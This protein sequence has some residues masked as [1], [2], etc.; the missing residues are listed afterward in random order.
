[1]SNLIHQKYRSDIQGLRALAVISVILFHAFPNIFTG[2]F[3]GVDIFF[4]ISGYL[5]S[6]IIFT[7]LNNKNFNIF[8]FYN[9]RIKRIF[10]S[11]IIVIFSSL[12]F[13]WFFLFTYEYINLGKYTAS[14][15]IFLSDIFSYKQSGYFDNTS[16]TKPMLHLWSLSVEWQFYILWPLLLIFSWKHKWS[17]FQVS[18]LI[19]ATSFL[20]NIILIKY[21]PVAS[22]YLTIARVWELIIGGILAYL[23][24]EYKIFKK[25]NNIQSTAGL[26][27]II[28]GF[29][30]INKESQFPGWLALLPTV[31]TFLILSAKPSSHLNKY[32]FSNK[33]LV[34][35]GMISYPLYLWHWPMLSFLHIVSGDNSKGEQKIIVILVSILFAW[36]T[37]YFVEKK[38][39]EKKF[40]IPTKILL[41]ITLL[42]FIF[43]L[44]IKVNGGFFNRNINKKLDF[45]QTEK[46]FSK[47]RKSDK[48]CASLN[49]LKL[50]DEEV[51]LSNSMEPKILFI[52]D[53]HSMALYSSIYSKKILIN[54]ILISGHTCLIYP[55]LKYE[56]SGSYKNCR[57]I[58]NK[59]LDV[60][61]NIPS[62]ETIIVATRFPFSNQDS[63]LNSKYYLDNKILKNE[64]A[65]FIGTSNLI[66]QLL[67]YGKRII[68]VIDT[69]ELNNTPINCTQ[70]TSFFA[71]LKKCEIT[72]NELNQVRS[73]YV[74]IIKKINLKYP[75][76]KIFDPTDFFC[77]HEI[78]KAKE[79]EQHLYIDQN[80]ISIYAS[81]KLLEKM[82]LI[83]LINY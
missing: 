71:Q 27:L 58:S 26:F 38:L 32:L 12:V 5:I 13:G 15:I 81:S 74:D 34:Y 83:G 8:Y 42:I 40:F 14:S 2:G 23:K 51:C 19:L 44:L 73:K 6:T 21:N 64:D 76:I 69:P 53:S 68:I 16:D 49:N 66:E 72:I 60:A 46:L 37:Y 25:N 18:L 77:K 24:I 56:K 1:M 65:F 75:Q 11:L 57:E 48:S 54:S 78:C 43:S 55:N 41:I 9:R 4:V 59:A 33:I 82:K 61:N 45:L 67:S 29:I 20:I 70:R 79:S 17:I 35:I 28:L 50:L 39:N 36:L 80:H 47:S 30:F 10:P 63:G 62:I 52:G 7:N 3:I 22:F 31:G